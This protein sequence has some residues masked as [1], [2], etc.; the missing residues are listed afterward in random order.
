MWIN[1]QKVPKR[2]G[3]LLVG[4]GGF[5]INLKFLKIL[6]KVCNITFQIQRRG[7]G[8]PNLE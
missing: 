6:K 1:F 3:G 5:L 8:Q 4:G 2:V 7:R